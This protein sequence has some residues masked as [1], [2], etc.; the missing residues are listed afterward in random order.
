MRSAEL[1][2][3]PPADAARV[4]RGAILTL[5]AYLHETSLDSSVEGIGF[6]FRSH[7][8]VS[9]PVLL[10]EAT[11]G[12]LHEHARSMLPVSVEGF[13]LWL[14]PSCET[15]TASLPFWH[16]R[17]VR[18]GVGL[19]LWNGARTGTLGCLVQREGTPFAL[20]CEH[21]LAEAD[22]QVKRGAV[23]SWCDPGHRQS[24]WKDLGVISEYGNIDYAAGSA[25][26]DSALIT[27]QDRWIPRVRGIG[28]IRSSVVDEYEAVARRIRLQKAG[29]ATGVT[30]GRVQGIRD[31]TIVMRDA[32][33][34][35]VYRIRTPEALEI[36]SEGKAIFC[37][38]GDSGAA[39]VD[40]EESGRPR[41][42]GLLC[43]TVLEYKGYAI[44]A[45]RVLA[46]HRVA[47]IGGA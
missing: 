22:Q 16:E 5:R 41:L 28:R 4:V 45:S 12:R 3:R 29:F 23:V 13:P 40:A 32:D 1:L 8:G 42:V 11:A 14:E 2:A 21:V 15:S 33:H 6:A 39:V 17:R 43:S 34:N 37:A 27:V 31:I 47:P 25:Q 46:R 24:V 18:G 38:P 30:F 44:P 10:V 9:V 20:T 19:R 36:V 35:P 7:L 26:V